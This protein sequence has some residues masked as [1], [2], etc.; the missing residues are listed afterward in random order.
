KAISSIQNDYNLLNPDFELTVINY[1]S[2]HKV[3]M[4]DFDVVVA[5]EFHNCSAF[6]KPSLRAKRLKERV[7][8]TPLIMLS[9]SP[10][11][12]SFSQ[13]YHPLW[14]SD[15]SP[16]SRYRNFYAWAKDYVSVYTKDIA[17]RPK[18]FY[19]RADKERILRDI[20]PFMVS[21][22]QEQAGFTSMV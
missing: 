10:S 3:P 6:P 7:G 1:E 19:D 9:G 11:P 14:V 15:Y 12:E 4:I 13:L 17:G 22:T 5:D 18:K 8:K 16:W 21:F 2:V 20:E